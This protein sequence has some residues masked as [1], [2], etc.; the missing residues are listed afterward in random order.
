[1]PSPRDPL[2]LDPS[3]TPAD[4]QSA[5]P[6]DN[7][8]QPV[9]SAP[10]AAATPTPFAGPLPIGVP[11]P[12]LNGTITFGGRPGHGATAFDPNDPIAAAAFGRDDVTVGEDGVPRTADGTALKTKDQRPRVISVQI[13]PCYESDE[14]LVVAQYATGPDKNTR[15]WSLY[16]RGDDRLARCV[17]D[18]ELPDVQLARRHAE[19][20]AHDMVD[21]MNTRRRDAFAALIEAGRLDPST[22][23]PPPIY[24]EAYAWERK[25]GKALATR[26]PP[27]ENMDTGLPPGKE[28]RWIARARKETRAAADQARVL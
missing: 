22:P 20:I 21:R 27:I 28:E 18:L 10:A 1:V 24:V 5:L 6:L 17:Y 13:S 23:E 16:L 2:E 14:H 12:Y 9:A 25:P 8:P 26:Q 3:A 15:F 7:P 11:L 4:A 19:S